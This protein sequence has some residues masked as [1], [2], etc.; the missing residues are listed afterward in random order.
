MLVVAGWIYASSVAMFVGGMVF[1]YFVLRP[2]L[3]RHAEE[4]TMKPVASFIRSRFRW[5]AILL[6]AVIMASG[7]VHIILAPPTGWSIVLLIVTVLV[8][9]AILWF[10]FRNAFARTSTVCA[11]EPSTAPPADAADV[12]SPEKVSEWKTAW[13]LNPAD[14][15]V[16]MEL[17]LIAGALIF[18]LLNVILIL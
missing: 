4:P 15:Q 7:I 10:Y 1:V 13:L 3:S 17:V 14:C 2:A 6:T 5:I 11:P 9:A 12:K 8:G 16:K 18:I